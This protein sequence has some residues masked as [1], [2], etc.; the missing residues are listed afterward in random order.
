MNDLEERLSAVQHCIREGRGPEAAAALQELVSSHPRDPRPKVLLGGL[1]LA[2]GQAG[3][4]ATL[5]LAALD[6]GPG[7]AEGWHLHGLVRR[8]L[9]DWPGALEAFEEA[10]RLAPGQPWIALNLADAC[11]Q[12]QDPARAL[13]LL[14]HCAPQLP[15]VEAVMLDRGVAL[16]ELGRLDEAEAA[17]RALHQ[18]NPAS[19]VVALN[20]ANTLLAMGRFTGEAWRLREARWAA[21]GTAPREMPM[22][23]WDGTP[24]PDGTLLLHGA[25]EGLG[26]AVMFIRFA[27]MA[28]QRV[29]RILLECPAALATLLA[30][31]PAVDGVVVQG[32]PL[33]PADFHLPLM[34]LP[35]ALG[36]GDVGACAMPYLRVPEASRI[37]SRPILDQRLDT[38]Q[39][40][41]G[42]GLVWAG[43]PGHRD[44][45]R[46][47]M[48]LEALAWAPLPE[49]FVWV[50][51]QK[52][53]PGAP[54][55][56]PPAG[57]AFLDLGDVLADFADT[58][59]ALSRLE[60]LVSVDTA[61]AHVAGALGLPVRL[62]LPCQA[63]WR[64][65]RDSLT[66]PWY[67]SFRLYRQPQPGNWAS[68]LTEV[69]RDLQRRRGTC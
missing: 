62:L 16:Y 4:A 33:P 48:P 34:S 12:C 44:D 10:H 40:R 13:A 47:S 20:L 58:A 54:A 57:T 25:Q 2:Q 56:E 11:L 21:L 39:G 18:A 46:R 9:T 65:M 52:R 51:L 26:D 27:E 28:R 24:S 42:I 68:V 69:A 67:P 45:A 43:N 6:C 5:A 63:E 31:H 35:A 22:P 17:Y 1:F 14:D 59:Y 53:A 7:L 66:T 64:W 55:P 50:S 30:G 8:H 41:R 38:L 19:P 49:P 23:A 29:G 37:P 15:G 36:G 32:Q 3:P 61:V 60:D